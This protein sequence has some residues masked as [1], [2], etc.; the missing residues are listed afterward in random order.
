MSLRL[1][2]IASAKGRKY[3]YWPYLLLSEESLDAQHPAPRQ[4]LEEVHVWKTHPNQIREV[5]PQQ[6]QRGA[7]GANWTS[8]HRTIAG[9]KW[10]VH[11][12]TTIWDPPN[13]RSNKKKCVS[14]KRSIKVCVSCFWQGTGTSALRAAHLTVSLY[15]CSSSSNT[16]GE[17]RVL[18]GCN[19]PTL[20]K[21]TFGVALKCFSQSVVRQQTAK[22]EWLGVGNKPGTG[23]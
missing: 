9:A 11:F 2:P 13:F 21:N 15:L 22:I 17:W 4:Y 3:C 12:V 6:K 8:A 16:R 18:E 23:Y 7:V 5:L 10:W 20:Q 1:L 19:E 14:N